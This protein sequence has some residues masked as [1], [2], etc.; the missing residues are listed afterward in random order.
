MD[1]QVSVIIAAPPE[2]VWAVMTAVERW[3]EWTPSVRSIRLLDPEPIAVGTRALIRQPK[4]PP[5]VW[6]VTSVEPL[7]SFVWQTGFPGLRVYAHHSV[8]PVAGG[9]RATLRLRYPDAVGRLIGRLTRGI[10]ERYLGYEAD[11][12]KRRSES[13]ARVS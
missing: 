7:Q 6:T 4:F 2:T 11:G 12:L 5:A 13:L 10:T 8:E 1:F 3:H 9:T